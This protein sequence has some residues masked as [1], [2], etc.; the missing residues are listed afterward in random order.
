MPQHPLVSL[1]DGKKSMRPWEDKKRS[2]REAT[3]LNGDIPAIAED[4]VTGPSAELQS[5]TCNNIGGLEN[6]LAKPAALAAVQ[7]EY[8][9]A[10][11]L[12]L[13]L[14]TKFSKPKTQKILILCGGPNVR[15]VSLYNLFISAGFECVNYDRLNGQQ[16]DL[17]DD[18]VKDKILHDIAA[19]EYAAAFA[20]P[21]CCS[22]SKLHNLPGPPPLR[23]V[24]GP[25]RYGIASNSPEQKE[26]LS[27]FS[28]ICRSPGCSKPRQSMPARFRC[29]IWMNFEN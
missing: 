12:I 26:Q 19:G 9:G 10:S 6:T 27:I 23:T 8:A 4:E 13:D 17:V 21:E 20:S 24:D 15:E 2:A 22:F 7:P 16:F 11:N 1:A 14:R 18:A 29:P 28:P 3:S 25:E 5:T